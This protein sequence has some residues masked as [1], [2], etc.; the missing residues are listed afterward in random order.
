MLVYGKEA[1]LPTNITIPSFALVQ[2]IDENPS[3]S[4]QLRQDQIFKMEEQ[5]EK[6]KA[7]HAHHQKIVKALFDTTSTSS[8]AFE[9]GDLVLTWDKAHE[10]K[11]K[12]T[13]FQRLWLGPFQI[14]EKIGLSTFLLQDLS[15]NK[16]S[17]PVNGRIL[18][19]YFS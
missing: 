8:K 7:I 17:L 13:K 18:K 3:S 10:E 9:I 14:I 19:K 16:D 1:V 6:A 11:S 5:R 4:L 15:S 2:F 12:H